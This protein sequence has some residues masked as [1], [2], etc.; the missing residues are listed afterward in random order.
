[1]VGKRQLIGN[2]NNVVSYTM[3]HNSTNVLRKGPSSLSIVESIC[4]IGEEAKGHPCNYLK[5]MGK[6]INP[7]FHA[8]VVIEHVAVKIAEL[9]GVPL[10]GEGSEGSDDVGLDEGSDSE[11]DEVLKTLYEK[12]DVPIV[13]IFFYQYYLTLS[14]CAIKVGVEVS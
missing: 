13:Y 8:W 10:E 1:M 7:V 12:H 5:T 9:R 3:S 4:L 6:S 2:I 14:M 11:S